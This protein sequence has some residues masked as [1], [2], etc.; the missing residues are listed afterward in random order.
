VAAAYD[1]TQVHLA[2]LLGGLESLGE[3]SRVEAD[4]EL[5]ETSVCER[6]LRSKD[7]RLF[8]QEGRLH[9]LF[10]FDDFSDFFSGLTPF[11]SFSLMRFMAS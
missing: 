1:V 7:K 3:G 11:F 9:L 2:V 4:G 10:S 6:L 8:Q 5:A